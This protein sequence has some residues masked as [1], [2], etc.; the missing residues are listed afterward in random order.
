M[1]APEGIALADLASRT[2]ARV[3]GDGS[4]R[5]R[6][7]TTLERGGEDAIAFLANP[8]YRGQLART[9]A[10]AVIVAP[11]DAPHTGLPKLVAERPY[12]VY[13]KVAALLHPS[14]R[15]PAGIHPS[16]VIAPGAV[17]DADA[18][19]GPHVAIG[20]GA[21]IGAGAVI[22]P[23]CSIGAN[24]RIGEGATLHPN[25]VVYAECVIG[26]RCTPLMPLPPLSRRRRARSSP[27]GAA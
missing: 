5:V 24:V 21:T 14:Q 18:T 4:V 11:A 19:I 22:G 13:A 8:K 1:A 25:V 26:P 7:V 9:T 20:Q 23:G 3:E 6:R 12:A 16:A 27:G 15:P 2:G 17:V 10:A